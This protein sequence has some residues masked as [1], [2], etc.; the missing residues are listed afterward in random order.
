VARLFPD[1]AKDE[2][3]YYRRTGIFPIMHTVVVRRDI[4]DRHSWVAASLLRAFSEAKDRALGD[5]HDSDALAVSLAWLIH[6]SEQE[7]Q[8]A[9]PTDMWA[10]GLEPN[11]HVLETLRRYMVEQGLLAR[12]LSVEEAFPVA[13]T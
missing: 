10:Y 2:R 8:L 6:Y 3:D 13:T 11:R 1:Y 4:L 12:E 7:R 9:M 5:L